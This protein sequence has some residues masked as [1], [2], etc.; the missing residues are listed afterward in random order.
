VDLGL[1][2]LPDVGDVTSL[3]DGTTDQYAWYLSA[4]QWRADVLTTAGETDTY[5]AG[6][7]GTYDWSYSSDLLT[8]IVGAE[9]VRLPRAAD[10]L[11]PALAE[12]LVSY[13]GQS[14][15][16]S[17]LPGQRV[18]GVDAAGLRL[19]PGG[20]TSTISAVDVWADPRT[21]LAVE[22][23]IFGR[24]SPV[25]VLVSRFLDVSFAR[26]ALATV[27][28][29]VSAGSRFAVSNLPDVARILHGYGPGL[30]TTLGGVPQVAGVVGLPDLAAYGSGFGRFAVV[31][32][33]PRTGQSLLQAA[34]SAGVT[35]ELGRGTAVIIQTPL[36]TVLVS[37]Q[38]N[39]PIYLLAGTVTATVLEHAARQ[40]PEYQ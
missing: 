11:P 29:N 21:G 27:T 37:Q 10:L 39:G 23:E 32:L 6:P 19:T 30:P 1:P 13:A 24:Y 3:L 38:P 7:D 26:P 2:N 18:A 36:M 40:L 15:R 14:T 17:T 12:R 22:V 35:I 20:S 4:D 25:P 31:P 28:P 9:P 33:P 34:S 5:Q 16:V 8:Q